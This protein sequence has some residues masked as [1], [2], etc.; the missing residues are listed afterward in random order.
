MADYGSNGTMLARHLHGLGA[1]DDPLITFPGASASHLDA[2]YLYTDRLG[3][4]IARYRRD[5]TPAAINW[6]SLP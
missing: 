5:G 4:V 1:G 2:E 6:G 3:S